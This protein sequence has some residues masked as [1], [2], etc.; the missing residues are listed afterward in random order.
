M[1]TSDETLDI[2]LT[3]LR[4]AHAM[5]SQA[6]SVMKPQLNRLEHYPELKAMLDQHIRETEGQ[7]DRLDQIFDSLGESPSGMKDTILSAM[8]TMNAMGHAMASD[9]V[10]K[11]SMADYM[12]EHFEIAS[13]TSLITMARYVGASSAIP[14]LE[15]SLAE[16]RRFAS[17]LH[18]NLPGLTEQFLSRTASGVQADV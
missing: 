14:L 7:I 6:L 12:F 1:D 13:Y 4:N 5:E 15:E 9:E 3:G 11:N 18:D 2:F 17:W 8:G 10:L 16:E